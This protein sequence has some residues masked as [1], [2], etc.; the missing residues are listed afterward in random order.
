[1]IQ[2]NVVVDVQDVGINAQ[3]PQSRKSTIT[4]RIVIA[5][6][7]VGTIV[8]CIFAILHHTSSN[9]ANSDL[10]SVINPG[11][12]RFSATGANGIVEDFD[13]YSGVFVLHEDGNLQFSSSFTSG[14]LSQTTTLHENALYYEVLQHNHST[15]TLLSAGCMPQE[16]L[17][18]YKLLSD[19]MGTGIDIPEDAAGTP[20]G[21]EDKKKFFAFEGTDFVICFEGRL[22]S[23]KTYFIVCV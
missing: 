4:K 15:S 2:I 13:D 12:Y 11:A 9:Q 14:N 18:P 6:L 7:L 17:P 10:T 1:M 19:A 22:S 20:S 16:E 23:L 3:Q 5:F 21:C 8:G